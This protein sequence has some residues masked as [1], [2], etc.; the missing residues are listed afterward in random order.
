MAKFTLVAAHAN[1]N[2]HQGLVVKAYYKQDPSNYLEIPYSITVFNQW[3]TVEVEADTVEHK[4]NGVYEYPNGRRTRCLHLFCPK[5]KEGLY[6]R[7]YSPA[8]Q[9]GN[10]LNKLI[11]VEA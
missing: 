7:G 9:I 1:R 5:T 10:L 4:L 3:P 6:Y 2:P 11:K 8:E